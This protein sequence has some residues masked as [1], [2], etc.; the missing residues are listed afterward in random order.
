MLKVAV[1]GLG[2]MGQRHLEKWLQM[3]DCKVVGLVSS[4]QDKLAKLGKEGT[5]TFSTLEALLKDTEADVVDICLP[6]YLHYESIKK[7]A[8]SGRHIICEKP[9][10]MNEKEATSI[11]AVCEENNVQLYVGQTLRF[12]P[13]Y[14]NAHQQVKAGAIGKPGVVRLARGTAYPGGKNAWYADPAKSGGVIL[15]L[16]I[17]DIDWLLWTFGDV[18][19]VTAKHIKRSSKDGKQIEYALLILRLQ[20]GTLAHIELSWAKEKTEASFEL[21]GDQGMIENDS[22]TSQPVKVTSKETLADPH[23]VLFNEFE[24]SSVFKQLCHFR[25]C[26]LK[27]ATPAITLAE[28][29][30]AIKV[31]DAASQS[32]ITGQPV[33]LNEGGE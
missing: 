32:V 22:E 9:L 13:E 4:D 26:L 14:M 27:G 10:A 16:G 3:D 15:D 24:A 18:E 29:L 30:K 7:T 25:D 2:K 21:C 17:H 11:I 28:V 1:V 12:S 8:E 6:T 19:R 20:D 33:Y 31:A 5:N 23:T